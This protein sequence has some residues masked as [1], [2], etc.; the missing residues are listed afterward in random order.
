[1]QDRYD[2]IQES[3]GP[4]TLKTEI[5]QP[6]IAESALPSVLLPSHFGSKFNQFKEIIATMPSLIKKS[7]LNEMI[8]EE[9]TIPGWK[10]DDLF[11]HLY[12]PYRNMN[13]TVS[14]NSLLHSGKRTLSRITSRIR[15][16]SNNSLIRNRLILFSV[17]HSQVHLTL[18]HLQ[19]ALFLVRGNQR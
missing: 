15:R 12:V 16:T 7:P 3:V 1:M 10:F 14:R 11:R 9:T 13:L 8:S 6:E 2:K 17:P 5:A 19:L 18:D 4:K